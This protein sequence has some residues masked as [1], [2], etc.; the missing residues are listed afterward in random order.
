MRKSK[1]KRRREEEGRAGKKYERGPLNAS[2]QNSQNAL[3]QLLLALPVI[4]SLFPFPIRPL[5]VRLT[6]VGCSTLLP[7]P[8][9]FPHLENPHPGLPASWSRPLFRNYA[10]TKETKRTKN[11]YLPGRKRAHPFQTRTTRL[12]RVSMTNYFPI[13]PCFPPSNGPPLLLETGSPRPQFTAASTTRLDQRVLSF[14]IS[15]SRTL[16]RVLC[17]VARLYRFA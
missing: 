12:P 15:T 2:R 16:F 13:T 5:S 10:V 1:K 9:S 8:T 6:P 4:S 3:E 17:L 14:L 11:K 7:V